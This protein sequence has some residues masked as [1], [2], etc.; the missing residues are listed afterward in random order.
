MKNDESKANAKLT[1]EPLYLTVARAANR[2]SIGKTKVRDLLLLPDAPTVYK[3]GGT[4]M[5]PLK[6]FDNFVFSL[7]EVRKL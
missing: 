6:E 4:V 5:I 7:M 3:L 2:Y 1:D